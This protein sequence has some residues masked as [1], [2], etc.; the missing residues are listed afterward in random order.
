MSQS[1]WGSKLLLQYL[2]VNSCLDFLCSLSHW[3]CGFWEGR[4]CISAW[5]LGRGL[6]GCRIVL[7]LDFGTSYYSA[8]T[9]ILSTN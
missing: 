5:T 9:S 4:N 1:I 2:D 6:Q 3:F 8:V 7:F